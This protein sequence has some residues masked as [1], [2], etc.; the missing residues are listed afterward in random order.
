MK[1]IFSQVSDKVKGIYLL[2][3]VLHGV[4]FMIAPSKFSI[5]STQ[6]LYPFDTPY[7]DDRGSLVIYD[8]TEF[9]FYLIVPVLLY[10]AYKLIKPEPKETPI[11]YDTR[12]EE[13]I[14]QEERF[15]RNKEQDR[16]KK[17][18][19]QK[20]KEFNKIKREKEKMLSP[21]AYREWLNKQFD[22]E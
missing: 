14:A 19:N 1:K 15:V 5:Y 21:D 12:S 11:K 20:E 9:L 6:Y 22:D 10:M 16:L 13:S 7:R 17:E 3:V 18:K 4:L 8:I 2:W